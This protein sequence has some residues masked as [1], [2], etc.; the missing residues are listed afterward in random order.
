MYRSEWFD[1]DL[2]HFMAEL[3]RSD[4]RYLDIGANVGLHVLNASRFVAADH[5]IC[6]EPNPLNLERLRF[7]LRTNRIESAAILPVA[8]SN[9]G[10]TT[11]LV[12]DDVFSRVEEA[13]TENR[14]LRSGFEVKTVRLDDVVPME[15]IH[16]TKLDVEGAEWQALVGLESHIEKGL[17][18]VLVIELLGHGRTY[19]VEEKDLVLWLQKRGYHLGAYRHD[20]HRFDFESPLHGDVWALSDKGID[21]VAQRMGFQARLK[22][23]RHF[24]GGK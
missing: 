5:I 16:L 4:D 14:G 24:C 8:A 3:L 21:W 20:E 23:C 2:M 18:P 11:R 13:G 7:C 22:P 9:H 17:L 15:M 12:G 19:G 1:W 10:G 6:V